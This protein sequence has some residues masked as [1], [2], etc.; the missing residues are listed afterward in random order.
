VQK[1]EEASVTPN[2]MSYFSEFVFFFLFL[3]FCLSEI[4]YLCS[5]EN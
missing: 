2:E 4:F 5:N 1:Y 3:F